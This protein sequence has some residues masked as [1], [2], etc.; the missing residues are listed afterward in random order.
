MQPGQNTHLPPATQNTPVPSANMPIQSANTPLA[1]S[2]LNVNVSSTTPSQHPPSLPGLTVPGPPTVGGTNNPYT[3]GPL[4]THGGP[5]LP[6]SAPSPLPQRSYSVR[7]GAGTL[8]GYLPGFKTMSPLVGAGGASLA[9]GMASSIGLGGAGFIGS[10]PAMEAAAYPPT[11]PVLN[12][13][14]PHVSL[15]SSHPPPQP[16]VLPTQPGAAGGTFQGAGLLATG[17]KQLLA[18]SPIPCTVH[19]PP[20]P[21]PPPPNAP[22]PTAGTPQSA[23]GGGLY[24]SLGGNAGWAR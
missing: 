19:P 18:Q 23:A 22:P 15:L 14:P 12:H 10:R 1:F 3:Y 4:R 8:G 6:V 5:Q 11:A 9:G 20:P 17:G 21:P 16:S 2:T 7:G 13:T 24:Q